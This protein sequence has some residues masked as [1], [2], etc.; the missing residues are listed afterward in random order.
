M[1]YSSRDWLKPGLLF[2][3]IKQVRGNT[4]QIRIACFFNQPFDDFFFCV[5]PVSQGSFLYYR[6]MFEPINAWDYPELF[7]LQA[8]ND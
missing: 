4:Q 2:H 1:A 8:D 6:P 7:R 5:P 3:N